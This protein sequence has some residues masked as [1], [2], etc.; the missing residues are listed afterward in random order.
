KHRRVG[1]ARRSGDEQCGEAESRAAEAGHAGVL[2][3]GR[4]AGGGRGGRAGAAPIMVGETRGCKGE[5]GAGPAA[6]GRLASWW[7]LCTQRGEPLPRP[8]I[9]PARPR[10][11][12]VAPTPLTPQQEALAHELADAL[13]RGTTDLIDQIARTLAAT[14]D[15][16]LFGDTELQ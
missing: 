5:A 9:H 14:T 13:R 2:G 8:E 15:H 16:T 6:C 10:G 4:E 12:P 11:G 7:K 1:G 3:G